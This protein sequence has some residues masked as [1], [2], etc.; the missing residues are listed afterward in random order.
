M[1]RD[2]TVTAL[3]GLLAALIVIVVS[4]VFDFIEKQG[5]AGSYIPKAIAIGVILLSVFYF[6]RQIGWL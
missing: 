5:K 3:S 4:K 2:L 6:M 1:L